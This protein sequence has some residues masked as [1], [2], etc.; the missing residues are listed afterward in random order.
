MRI[1]CSRVERSP[2]R[3][4]LF[5]GLTPDHTFGEFG[6]HPQ[7]AGGSYVTPRGLVLDVTSDDA[8]VVLSAR[9]EIDLGNAERLRETIIQSLA[10]GPAT[11]LLDC[12]QIAFID[13]TGI[14]VLL[15]T[16]DQCE[17]SGIELTILPSDRL[18]KVADT[19][20]VSGLLGFDGTGS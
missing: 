18:R 20:G 4:K 12:T 6:V 15:E 9:G 17:R 10:D 16:R 14:R 8:R 7:M 11:L 3:T 19:L 2:F 1:D 13:S 5:N